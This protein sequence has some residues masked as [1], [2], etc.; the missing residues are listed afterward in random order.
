[1]RAAQR[2]RLRG[3]QPEG[4]RSN[5]TFNQLRNWTIWR[6]SMR[7]WLQVEKLT[8]LFRFG[9]DNLKLSIVE[10]AEPLTFILLT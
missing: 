5:S 7:P 8:L 9:R 10:R 4:P 6:R 3:D 1:M 2:T